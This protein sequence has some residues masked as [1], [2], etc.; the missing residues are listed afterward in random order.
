MKDIGDS[1]SIT[2]LVWTADTR[3]KLFKKVITNRSYTSDGNIEN[4][5]DIIPGNLFRDKRIVT[6]IK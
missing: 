1:Y 6:E 5:N 2:Y 4:V 3:A